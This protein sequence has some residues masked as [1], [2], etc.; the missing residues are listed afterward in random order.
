MSAPS[1]R[2]ERGF[3]LIE[4]LVAT[5]ILVIGLIGVAGLLTSVM[6][7]NRGA[8]NRT[9]AQQILVEKVAQFHSTAY[10]NLASGS[11]QD[12]VG[13]VVFTRQW[14]VNPNTPIAN[15]STIALTARWVE[16]R[17]TFRVRQ[18]TILSAN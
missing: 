9:R 2:N 4:V 17:D 7:A 3:T 18:S 5:V 14:T 16:R 10:A 13:G 6:Q 15:A 8:M 11:D 12:T 1:W